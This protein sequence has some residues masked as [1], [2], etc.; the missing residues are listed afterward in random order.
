M[1]LFT[2]VSLAVSQIGQFWQEKFIS[3]IFRWNLFF[4]IVQLLLLFINF[5]NLPPQIPLFYSKPWGEGQLAP[6]SYIF[7]LPALS[8]MVLLLNNCL[9]VFFLKS[10]QLLTRLLIILSLVFSIF[11]TITLYQIINLVL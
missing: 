3:L 7:L 2:H 8:A 4:I 10:I 5:N 1:S 9:A 11:A 6:V